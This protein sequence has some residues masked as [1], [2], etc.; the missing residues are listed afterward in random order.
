M[1]GN[2]R[3]IIISTDRLF[4]FCKFLGRFAVFWVWIK[5]EGKKGRIFLLCGSIAGLFSSCKFVQIYLVDLQ[6][7]I[8][9]WAL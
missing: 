2:R 8:L 7:T 9:P 5:A 3:S 6:Q 1:E 4:L